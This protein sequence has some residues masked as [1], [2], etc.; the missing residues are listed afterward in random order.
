LKLRLL[1]RLGR[2]ER[3]ASIIE[4]ALAAPVLASIVVVMADLASAYSMTLQIEQAAQRTIEQVQNQKAVATAYNTAITTE[5]TNAMNDAGYTVANGDITP[6][7]WLECGSDTTHQSFTGS[8]ANAG[9]VIARY[10]SVRIT[11]KYTPF[12]PN[13]AWPNADSNGN[14]TIAGYAEVRIQ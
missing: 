12:F 14:I 9:D 13:R 8:C 6:D 3:G 5:A 1:T 2:D 7:S 10:V 4:L 11:H